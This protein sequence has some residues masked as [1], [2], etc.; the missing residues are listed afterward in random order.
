MVSTLLT[1]LPDL[2]IATTEPLQLRPANFVSGIIEM[3]VTFT[4]TTPIGAGPL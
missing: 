1:R 3:P 2:A 4:P